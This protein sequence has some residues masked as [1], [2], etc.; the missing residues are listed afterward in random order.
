MEI[1]S[2]ILNFLLAVITLYFRYKYKDAQE[3]IKILESHN[4][5]L[6]TFNSDLLEMHETFQNKICNTN[7][8]QC[9]KEVCECVDADLQPD[10]VETATPKR[11]RNY[12]RKK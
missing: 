1:T 3:T 5:E 12:K 11:K 6:M 2:L 4:A 9:E 10:T 7:V 8:E